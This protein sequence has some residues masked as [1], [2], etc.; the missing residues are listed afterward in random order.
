MMRKLTGIV[1]LTTSIGLALHA[2]NWP[3]W[4]GETTNGVSTETGLPATWSDSQNV[5]WKAAISGSGI[6]SPIVWQDKV[7]VTSQM[8]RGEWRQ[9][10]R[11]FQQGDAAAAGERPLE[12]TAEADRNAPVT[13]LVSAYDR[14]TGKKL[15]EYTGAAEGDLPVVHE[16]HNLATAS[17]TTDGERIYAWFGTGQVI[18]LD[19]GGK[20]VWERHL[21]NEFGALDINHGHGSS[22]VV[23][24]DSLILLNYHP[25]S[26]YLMA[27]D[28]RTGRTKWKADRE[29]GTVSYSTPRVV[30]TSSGGAEILVNSSLGLSA[31][32]ASNGELLWHIEEANRFPIPVA[33]VHDGIIYASRGY[34]SGPYMAIRPGGRGDIAD[35]HVVWRVAT[36]APYVSSLIYYDGLIYMVGDV[37]VLSVIDAKTG[38][39]THQE[40][41]GGVYSASPVAGDGKVYLFS[42]GGETIVLAAGPTPRILARN[43]LSARQLGSPAV[44]GGRLFIRSDDTLFAIGTR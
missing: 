31:H 40:R 34:R 43:Q 18:A 19:M 14:V 1:L 26:S 36:G 11:L 25:A 21:G 27:V 37:G 15:W 32:N 22:P 3:N 35:S 33:V 24:K 41:I 2:E 29:K 12:G 20:L 44:S 8:G 23:Y 5:A 17:P 42:E 6:S 7:I 16:K 4:R 39:R 9:G 28:V 38:E 30:E 13:F 10:P